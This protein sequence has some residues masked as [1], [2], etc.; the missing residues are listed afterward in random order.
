MLIKVLQ[1]YWRKVRPQMN[2]LNFFQPLMAMNLNQ[3]KYDIWLDSQYQMILVIL[4]REK[5]AYFH[6]RL[7]RMRAVGHL[8]N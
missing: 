1:D 4:Y 3:R 6:R 5:A 7:V 2:L 8:D